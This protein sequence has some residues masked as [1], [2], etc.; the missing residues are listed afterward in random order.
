MQ[1]SHT[2]VPGVT[3]LK[4]SCERRYQSGETSF[5][6]LLRARLKVFLRL[7]VR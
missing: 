7:G 2:S 3:L 4:R 6:P 1:K 5:G